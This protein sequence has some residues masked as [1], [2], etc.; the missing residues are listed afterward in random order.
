MTT[1]EVRAEAAAAAGGGAGGASLLDDAWRD[2]R[3][4]WTFWGSAAI[5]AVVAAMAAVPGLC[6]GISSD[7]GTSCIPR[8]SKTAKLRRFPVRGVGMREG[9]SPSPT[10]RF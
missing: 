10:Q 2:L 1:E 8:G 9:T 5:I 7:P 3:R 6:T 4:R